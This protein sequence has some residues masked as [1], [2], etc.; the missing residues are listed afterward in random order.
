MPW[1]SSSSMSRCCW[2]FQAEQRETPA[3]QT[4]LPVSSPRRGRTGSGDGA[5]SRSLFL[6]AL[7]QKGWCR[8]LKLLPAGSL[9]SWFQLGARRSLRSELLFLEGLKARA[10]LPGLLLGSG[11][12]SWPAE[13]AGPSAGDVLAA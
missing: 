7:S 10:P 5:F 12:G 8:L 9:E 1:Y 4:R 6:I 11:H 13:L 2:P 3:L